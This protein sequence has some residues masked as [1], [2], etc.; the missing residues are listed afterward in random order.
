M[1]MDMVNT[2][3]FFLHINIGCMLF[4]TMRIINHWSIRLTIDCTFLRIVKWAKNSIVLVA[5]LQK[6]RNRN[7]EKLRKIVI[8]S[9]WNWKSLKNQCFVT[10]ALYGQYFINFFHKIYKI[11]RILD[12]EIEHLTIFTIFRNFAIAIFYKIKLHDVAIGI[13]IHKSRLC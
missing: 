5:K 10:N 4:G 1:N 9:F 2:E 8:F 13:C 6:W 11:G 7:R 3:F 12:T